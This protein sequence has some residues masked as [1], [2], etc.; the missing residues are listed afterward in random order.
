MNKPWFRADRLAWFVEVN[1]KQIPLGKDERFTVPPKVKPKEP[2]LS[3]QKRYLAAMQAQAEPEDRLLSFCRDKYIESMAGCEP[4]SIRR[5]TDYMNL[6][7]AETGDPKVS[8]LKAHHVTE[9]LK[10][11][12][13]GENTIRQVI[14]TINA[15]LNHCVRQ[16]WIPKNPLK[17]KVTMPQARRREDVMTPEDSDKL[18]AAVREPFKSF[19]IFLAG[20]GCRP[21]EAR[22]ALIEDWDVEKGILMVKNKTRKKTGK[23]QRPLFIST[24]MAEHLKAVIGERKSGPVFLNPAGEKWK[25]DT[26]R[27]RMKRK[28]KELKITYGDRMYSARHA[29][30]GQAIHGGMPIALVALSMGHVDTKQVMATYLHADPKAIREAIDAIKKPQP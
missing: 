5:S 17:G 13:W 18:I 7:V 24:A 20:T 22:E 11:K 1:G 12:E 8:K 3:V 26:L 30:C 2:P 4:N 14:I 16:D 9:F 27:V 21:I 29:W 25:G 23:M 19:L 28:C 6:F 10:G 15:C